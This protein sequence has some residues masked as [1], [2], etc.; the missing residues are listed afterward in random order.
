MRKKPEKK[1]KITKREVFRDEC[2]Y[3]NREE[4][5]HQQ[6]GGGRH[7]CIGSKECRAEH[8]SCG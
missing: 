7:F 5:G 2:K 8:S 6:R 4:C 3:L 1:R